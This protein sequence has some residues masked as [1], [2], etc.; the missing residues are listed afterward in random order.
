MRRSQLQNILKTYVAIIGNIDK[1]QKTF[2]LVD[3]ESS[4]EWMI[5]LL[6]YRVLG[7]E[8]V[9][10]ATNNAKYWT[11]VRDVKY[12]LQRAEK[13][14]MTDSVL[15]ALHEFDLSTLGYSLQLVAHPAGVLATFMLQQYA[16]NNGRAELIGAEPGDVVIDGGACWGDTALYFADKVGAKGKLCCFEFL[17]ENIRVFEENMQRNPTLASRIELTQLAL[18][19]RSNETIRYMGNGPGTKLLNSPWDLNGTTVQTITIDDFVEQQGL[20]RVDLIKLDV[21]GAELSALKGSEQVLHRF[22]PKLA[23]AVYHNLL[24]LAVIP[25]Y[26]NGLGLGYKFYISHFTLHLEETIL[27]AKVTVS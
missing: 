21:E 20:L 14:S 7:A 3:N 4:R 24:D 15:G 25:Q 10:L 9:A 22:R 11:Y 13:T 6:A 27:F 12:C 16:Y 1:L 19:E 23:I 26:L 2:D 5:S 18:W 17:P 8:R